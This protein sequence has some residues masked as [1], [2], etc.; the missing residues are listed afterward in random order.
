MESPITERHVQALWYDG[1]LRPA[2]LRTWSGTPVRVVH[3]G[4]WNLESGPDFRRAVLEVGRERA[5]LVGDVEVH[6]RPSDWVAHRH[7]RDPA[8]SGVVAHVTWTAGPPPC[9]ADGLPRGCLSI[10]MGDAVLTRPDFSPYEI[11]LGA[12]P[13]ARLPAGPRPCE[14]ALAGRT[15]LAL[16]LIRAAG[17]RR[18]EFKA[19]R[20][21]S[22][23]VRRGSREK[24]FGSTVQRPAPIFRE[25]G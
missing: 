21:K 7:A 15:D 10:G 13:Y 25:R 16:S 5:R 9:G 23:L 4:S 20:M 24:R 22:L 1:A 18:L 3:P 11:D 12:Y 19:R 2:S 17:V 6:L 14:L 8:Y